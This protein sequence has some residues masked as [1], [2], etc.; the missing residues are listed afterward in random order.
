MTKSV[1]NLEDK[2]SSHEQEMEKAVRTLHQWKLRA[3]GAMLAAGEVFREWDTALDESLY[4]G[5]M[6]SILGI[7]P[8]ELSPRFETWISLIHADDRAE[9]QQEI[10][11][12]L[13][14]GGPFEAEYRARKNNGNFTLLLERGYFI[15]PS[16][17]SNPVLSSVIKDISELREMESRLQHTQRIEAFSNLTGGVAHD[18]NN[19][20]SVIIGYAQMMQEEIPNTDE[21]HSFLA[22]IEKAALRATSLTN[23]LL[24]FSKPPAI[25]RGAIS[26]NDLLLEVSKMLKRLLGEQI[27]LVIEPSENLATAQGDRSQIEQAFINLAVGARSSMP[28]GGKITITTKNEILREAKMFYGRTL[29]PGHY[30]HVEFLQTSRTRIENSASNSGIS[31]AQGV[32]EQNDG[33]L[34]VSLSDNN[35]SRCDIY[36]RAFEDAP[37]APAISEKPKPTKSSTILL[38]EDDTAMR[39]FIRTVLKR[40]GHVVVSASDGKDALDLLRKDPTIQPD[41]LLTD[42]VMPHVGGLALAE[43]LHKKFPDLSVLLISGHPDQ[44]PLAQQAGTNFSFLRKPFVTGELIS[45]VHTLLPRE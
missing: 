14:E 1:K 25:K 8:H 4:S 16:E 18:F 24:A 41:L 36:L 21:N 7:Y 28:E 2:A 45:K 37:Q 33:Q 12:V 40:V 19:M 5:A 3:E 30:L 22:E 42:M 32:I 15:P 10:E 38:V 6:E 9:Y 17:S 29:T 27:E 44:Q 35:A 34:F 13:R 39:R 23:Q 20:L 43:E 11:R 31:A 26:L